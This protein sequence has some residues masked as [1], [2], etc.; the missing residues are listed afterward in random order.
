MVTAQLLH[1]VA[2]SSR[3][4]AAPTAVMGGDRGNGKLD[5]L[6]DI[7]DLLEI[8]SDL[9]DNFWH[10]AVQLSTEKTDDD[11]W[12]W[13]SYFLMQHPSAPTRLLDWSDGA[14]IGLYFAPL[15]SGSLSL[16]RISHT[17]E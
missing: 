17:D 5:K 16:A 2:R 14:L 1:R 15:L 7:D 6:K 12:P 9:Y 4:S 3:V 8:E 10:S 13:D 11:N